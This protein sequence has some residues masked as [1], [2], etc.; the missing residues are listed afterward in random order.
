MDDLPAIPDPLFRD[1]VSAMDAGDVSALERLLAAHPE[2]VRD[3]LD[4]GDRGEKYFRQ[5]YL[6]WFVAE[7]PIRNGRLPENI[8]QVTRTI[9]QAA[10]RQGVDNLREQVDYALELVSSGQVPRE[11]GVQGELIDLL[12][13]A[14]ADPDKA[15]RA[16]LIHKEVAAFERLLDHGASLTLPAAVCTRRMDDVARLAPAASAG[17]RQAALSCAALYGHAEALSMLIDLDVDLN[18]YSPVGYHMHA[19]PLHHAVDSGSLD[20]VKILVEAGARL[21]AKDLSYQATP[22]GWAEHLQRPEIAAYLREQAGRVRSRSGD[23]VS[24]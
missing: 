24:R 23:R 20:A 1:A 18:A 21:D 22:L 2:L 4:S 10:E 13:E 6:L 17:D 5:P 3:R 15:M 8:A 19:T 16:A 12:L 14:G 9:L 11:C 7:N